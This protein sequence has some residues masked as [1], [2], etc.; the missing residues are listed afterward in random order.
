MT[1]YFFGITLYLSGRQADVDDDG[2]INY[3]EFCQAGSTA[4]RKNLNSKSNNKASTDNRVTT[5]AKAT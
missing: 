1:K 4:Q 2:I 3:E 5:S